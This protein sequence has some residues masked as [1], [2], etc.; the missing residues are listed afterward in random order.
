MKTNIKR[1]LL[2]IGGI[3]LILAVRVLKK[4]YREYNAKENQEQTLEREEESDEMFIDFLY[5]VSAEINKKCPMVVDKDTR[6]D[7][8]LVL[9]NKT[10]QYNYTLVNLEKEETDIEVLEKEF[11]PLLL[12]DVKTNPGLKIFR[13]RDVTLSYYYKD[14][15]GD[16]ILNFK[17]TP[18][19]YK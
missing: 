10:I 1:I 6:L 12:K 16:F 3:I 4:D 11:I 8:T 19:L 5:K 18:E 15:N 17:A 14:K 7:N 13:D 2:G 9:S